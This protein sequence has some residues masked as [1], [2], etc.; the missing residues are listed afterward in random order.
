MIAFML[1]RQSCEAGTETACPLRPKYVW[2]CSVQKS[3]A[4][5]SS[6]WFWCLLRFDSHCSKHSYLGMP[7]YRQHKK[8]VH[9]KRKDTRNDIYFCKNRI[10]NEVTVSYCEWVIEKS[11]ICSWG[12]HLNVEENNQVKELSWTNL[13]KGT[14]DTQTKKDTMPQWT[15]TRGQ[16]C[17]VISGIHMWR[18]S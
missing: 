18:V 17:V 9:V 1:K 4:P 15:E 11:C 7:S 16:P 13:I 8:K 2:P 6:R 10:K 3:L 5:P 14:E 12:Q